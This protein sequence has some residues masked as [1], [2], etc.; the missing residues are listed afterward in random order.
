MVQATKELSPV[1][2]LR[3]PLLGLVVHPMILITPVLTAALLAMAILVAPLE[4][5]L[6]RVAGETILL[7]IA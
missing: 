1:V 7:E 5:L 6:P 3:V 4:V 2:V